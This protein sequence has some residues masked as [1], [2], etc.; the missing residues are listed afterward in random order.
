MNNVSTKIE[1]QIA[2][3]EKKIHGLSG[4]YK[5]NTWKRQQEQLQRDRTA[6]RYR[7]QKQ[8]LE[9]LGEES[10]CRELTQ[11]E[12]ALVTG[13]FYENMRTYSVSTQYVREHPSSCNKPRFPASD[14]T[15]AARLLKAGIRDTA[16]LDQAIVFF[17]NLMHKA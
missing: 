11:L 5:T 15:A 4:D 10:A 8:M 7:A 1:N 17:D 2:S 16:A 9:Y 12:N 3:L 13:A 14:S 6:E